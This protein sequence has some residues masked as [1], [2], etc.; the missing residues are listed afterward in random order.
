[1]T[2]GTCSPAATRP[3]RPRSARRRGGSGRARGLVRPLSWIE[4][5]S[6]LLKAAE[7]AV[8]VGY[9]ARI[10]A[11]RCS[12]RQERAPAEIDAACETIDYLRYNVYFASQIY[13]GQ[14]RFHA[15]AAQPHGVPAAR[16]LRAHHQPVQLQRPSRQPEPGG[17]LMGNTDGL[18]GRRARLCSPTTT[19]CAVLMEAGLPRGVVNLR[20]R[21]GVRRGAHAWPTPCSRHPL[22]RLQRD[23]QRACGKRSANLTI[24]LGIR[25]S[26]AETGGKDFIFAHLRPMRRPWRRRWYWAPSSTRARSARRRRRPTSR[27]RSGRRS[28]T[29]RGL[30]PR[31]RVGRTCAGARP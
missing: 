11:A 24:P 31:I 6:I 4:R 10:A 25:A 9:R 29:R 3:A 20:A 27:R 5:A 1:V 7:L 17:S 13:A 28:G 14:P 18:E 30:I 19:S 22:H 21:P 8:E 2:T 12:G 26:S 16:R 15:G 23:V